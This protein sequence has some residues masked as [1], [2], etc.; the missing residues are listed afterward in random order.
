MSLAQSLQI[1]TGEQALGRRIFIQLHAGGISLERPA[2]CCLASAELPL[3][4][5]VFLG[6]YLSA[7]ERIHLGFPGLDGGGE[8]RRL[9]RAGR[10]G[11][12]ASTDGPEPELLLDPEEELEGVPGGFSLDGH[13]GLGGDPEGSC[14]RIQGGAL[15]RPPARL[16]VPD[17]R[18]GAAGP[19]SELPLRHPPRLAQCPY[20]ASRRHLSSSDRFPHDT[21]EQK[22]SQFVLTEHFRSASVTNYRTFLFCSSNEGGRYGAEF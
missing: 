18:V 15:Q 14:N 7:V 19:L 3:P 17:G 9:L 12:P 22:R 20:A 13:E 16:V 2:A 10:D 5:L 4:G 8:L 6:G 1:A 21:R 11:E